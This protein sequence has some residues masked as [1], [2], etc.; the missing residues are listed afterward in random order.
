MRNSLVIEKDI[1]YSDNFQ[2]STLDAKWELSNS[3]SNTGTATISD[4][5]GENRHLLIANDNKN[6][7]DTKVY[8][9]PSSSINVATRVY[10]WDVDMSEMLED[11]GFDAY[12]LFRVIANS[13]TALKYPEAYVDIHNYDSSG[14][15]GYRVTFGIKRDGATVTTKTISHT[16]IGQ[17][18]DRLKIK[19][20]WTTESVS[21]Y[22]THWQTGQYSVGDSYTNTWTVEPTT[23]KEIQMYVMGDSGSYPSVSN[24]HIY[25][26][27]MTP[28]EIYRTDSSTITLSALGGIDTYS[29][30]NKQA[31][32]VSFM[33]TNYKK[34]L[35]NRYRP[36]FIYKYSYIS[37]ETTL[38]S[39][40]NSV[41]SYSR[42]YL[43]YND[44]I[45]DIV[46]LTD[47]P[48][49][50]HGNKSFNP[51]CTLTFESQQLYT[52]PII[53]Y[54]PLTDT[55]IMADSMIID[56]GDTLTY[57]ITNDLETSRVII[58]W[59]GTGEMTLTYNGAT[60]SLIA[61]TLLSITAY[62][63][64]ASLVLTASE[65]TELDNLY[66]GGA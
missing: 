56:S 48:F 22:V 12:A 34:A 60:Y 9:T 66:I 29:I 13:G 30:Q 14:Y 55:Y 42:V 4:N 6:G 8:I 16:S 36:S 17:F 1:Y 46:R 38:E 24:L 25:S 64:S 63:G 5:I 44:V 7:G 28:D 65:D 59:N 47:T 57:K 39:L 53:D 15:I 52:Y 43:K 41:N 26:F 33:K 58:W 49:G 40:I 18:P 35:K 27:K 50:Y 51:F 19:I 62:I 20:V 2:Y 45:F 54:T 23:L 3:S 21:M 11:N 61:D 37:D 31:N 10:E 32:D